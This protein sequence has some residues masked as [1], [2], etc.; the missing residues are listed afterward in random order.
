MLQNNFI[1]AQAK[2]LF[3]TEL[4]AGNILNTAIV[5]LADTGEIWT[6]G[7]YF[8]TSLSAEEIENLIT[9]SETIEEFIKQVSPAEVAIS[10]TEPVNDEKI[11]IDPSDAEDTFVSSA[12]PAAVTEL[13]SSSSSENIIAAFGGAPEFNKILEQVRTLNN[14]GFITINN[15]STGGRIPATVKADKTANQLNI[16]YIGDNKLVTMVVTNTDGTFS[17]AVSEAGI[18][19]E[20]SDLS[21]YLAKDNTTEFTPTADYNPATKKY[22]DDSISTQATNIISQI[23]DSAPETLDTLNELAAA[24]GDDPNFATTI[25]NQIA[26]KADSVHTHAITDVTGLVNNGDGNSFLANDGTYKEIASSNQ[27][28][29]MSIFT[30]ESGTLSEED[31]QKVVNAYNNKVTAGY[32]EG[33]LFPMSIIHEQQIYAIVYNP[34]IPDSEDGVSVDAVN[35]HF[36]YIV[37]RESDKGFNV[38]SD[39]MTLQKSGDGTKFLSDDGTYKTVDGGT[40]GSSDSIL[41]QEEQNTILNAINAVPFDSGYSE[42]NQKN[43]TITQEQYQSIIN[44][45]PEKVKSGDTRFY[46]ISYDSLDSQ[47]VSSG[48]M[49]M[50]IIFSGMLQYDNT[51]GSGRVLLFGTRTYFD[52]Y[53]NIMGHVGYSNSAIEVKNNSDGTYP[54]T[55]WCERLLAS[56][57]M[58]GSTI[59]NAKVLTESEYAALGTTPETD[60]VLYFVT[61]D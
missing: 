35:L 18:G 52:L 11:W 61:P 45:L 6:H 54:Y 4:D 26:G 19:S 17:C 30:G 7:K 55:Y 38:I 47:S 9:S 12:L 58:D 27:Y 39:R 15:D 46:F 22:V 59:V 60:N 20:A 43:G 25:T 24:L 3:Q 2:A 57:I 42:G 1:Y 23:T 48:G 44:A 33:G 41:T 49:Q 36:M 21:N 40:T 50:G 16:S 28:L 53:H 31:Y 10:T 29:D 8:A 13:T 5:F 37:V 32:T 34:N 14:V 51:N 56:T